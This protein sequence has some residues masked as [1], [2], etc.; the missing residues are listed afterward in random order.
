MFSFEIC[1]CIS[2]TVVFFLFVSSAITK[3]LDSLSAYIACFPIQEGSE[4]HEKLLA[5]TS[6]I[7]NKGTLH[8]QS[9]A[10]ALLGALFTSKIDFH[11][12]KVFIVCI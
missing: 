10:K 8:L 4:I 11:D 9:E 12:K 3:V 2:D 6:V 5:A 1:F 7:I